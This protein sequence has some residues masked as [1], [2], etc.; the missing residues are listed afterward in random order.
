MNIE[1]NMNEINSVE[2]IISNILL[3]NDFNQMNTLI[4]KKTNS[5]NSQFLFPNTI[6]VKNSNFIS[7]NKNSIKPYSQIMTEE[8]FYETVE[9]SKDGLSDNSRKYQEYLYGHYLEAVKLND[10]GY[11]FDVLNKA[12]EFKT[13]MNYVKDLMKDIAFEKEWRKDFGNESAVEVLKRKGNL[14]IVNIVKERA[15]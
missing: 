3:E 6:P 12:A 5:I 7:V 9:A 13:N 15:K 11:I 1:V 10:E 8:E 2:K 14:R 4:N